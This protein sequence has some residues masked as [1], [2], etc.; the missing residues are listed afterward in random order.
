M[1]DPP[2]AP[3]PAWTHAR[4]IGPAAF[5]AIA[6]IGLV[7]C[8]GARTPT[9]RP[10][11]A[12]PVSSARP[13]AASSPTQASTATRTEGRGTDPV[14]IGR[15]IELA[16]LTGRIVFDDFED[17][18]T[19]NADGSGFRRITKL[20][21]AEFDG[22]WSPDGRSI[23]Y[24]DSRRGINEDDEIY[25]VAADGSQARNLT[26]NPAANDWGPDWSPDGQWI[27]FNSDRDGGA[28]GGY[29]V[30]PDGTDLR[31][32][33][34]TGW[35]EY[36]SFSPDGR[37]IAF[38]GHAG[39]GY[40]VYTV[41]LVTGRT[42]QLTDSPGDDTWPVWSPDG[43]SIAFSS[44]RD[45]CTRAE[46]TVDCWR[47]DDPGEHHD[48]WI[49]DPDGGNQRRVSPEIGQFMAWSP[50]SRYLLVSGRTLFVVRPDGTGRVEIRPPELGRAAGGI[51]DWTATP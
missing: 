37:R 30:H 49:M 15:P 21:G 20:P 8:D 10:S 18:F 11:A 6:L 2:A 36:P 25:I 50:D 48:V 9:P 38:T 45:D 32:I 22:A 42:T 12:V 3:A 13:G 14:V 23:V 16:S 7:A 44:E 27:A 46:P 26:M 41:E 39:S 28:L 31:P 4:L 5:F 43:R 19:M 17:V 33:Q 35:F 29:L 34:A 40:D 47:S 1:A 24:R 51:P